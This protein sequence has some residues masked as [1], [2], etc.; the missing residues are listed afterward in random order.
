MTITRQVPPIVAQT[1]DDS[2][3]AAA[4][5]SW[6]RVDAGIA[7]RRQADLIRMWGEG[8]TGGITPRTKIPVIARAM[9]LEFGGFE[10]PL[11][12]EILQDFLPKGHLFC[13]YQREEDYMH[14]VI[15][16]RYSDRGNVSY[17]DPD[18]GGSDRWQPLSWFEARG[19]YIL[20]RKR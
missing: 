15:I 10:G 16:Y 4:L 9:G 13:A 12:E 5:E 14:A 1:L 11:L 2:C 18:N 7:D 8:P 3:W 17:M 19:P 20:L 6:S